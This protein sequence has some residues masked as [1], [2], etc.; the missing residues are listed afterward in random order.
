[1]AL[2]LHKSLSPKANR[3]T[4]NSDFLVSGQSEEQYPLTKKMKALRNLSS[5]H[6]I[7]PPPAQSPTGKYDKKLVVMRNIIGMDRIYSSTKYSI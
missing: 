2:I 1:M 4:I 7:S 5:N 3:E 6:H